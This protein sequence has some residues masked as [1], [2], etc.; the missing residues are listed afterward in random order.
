MKAEHNK[1]KTELRQDFDRK[2]TDLKKKYDLKMAK[3]RQEMETYRKK[4]IADLESKKDQKIK[5]LTK[6]HSQKYSD[7]KT[8]YTEITAT[9]LDLI[10]DL[11]NEISEL[12]N[13]GEKDKKTL[14]KVERERR[15]LLEPYK[16]LEIEIKKLEE[17]IKKQ[18]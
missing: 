15:E 6:E 13:A 18:D 1:K 16:A 10:K 2:A 17:D 5:Q 9:N 3:L 7:I 14:Q 11:R 12:Y 4:V 8:Y